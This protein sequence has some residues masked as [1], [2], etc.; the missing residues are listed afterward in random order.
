MLLLFALLPE[1]ATLATHMPAGVSASY[2]R[3]PDVTHDARVSSPYWVRKT[4]LI[5]NRFFDLPHASPFN[6]K[7]LSL[8]PL[9]RKRPH[10]SLKDWLIRAN[11]FVYRITDHCNTVE[12][13]IGPRESAGTALYGINVAGAVDCGL[14]SQRAYW[15]GTLLK[16]NGVSGSL[17]GL[18][19]HV[20][21]A[22]PDDASE[23]HWVLD[24]DY[25]TTPF[26]VDLFSSE[27]MRTAA[28][29]HYRFLDEAGWRQLY[30]DI[31]G[32]YASTENNA[33][34]DMNNLDHVAFLQS[35][36]IN[37]LWK[38]V[39]DGLRQEKG[40]AVMRPSVGTVSTRRLDFAHALHA[41]IVAAEKKYGIYGH[42]TEYVELNVRD[43][44]SHSLVSTTESSGPQL[45]I[46][47]WG[48]RTARLSLAKRSSTDCKLHEDVDGAIV[49]KPHSS[50]SI[51]VE[52]ACS[53]SGLL[54]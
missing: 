6:A 19:G 25:G 24:P 26:L 12:S 37:R 51:E 36:W 29:Q 3:L 11:E 48:Y 53:Y 9:L 30:A 17:L 1:S 23:K 8:N 27:E 50:V 4:S 45:R 38:I 49:V 42:R 33:F 31:V 32:F 43:F 47:N 46:T 2:M 21:L 7:R 10:E 40:S 22:I 54:H 18:M 5:A 34:Y 14:C 39:V 52:A 13:F 20:V 35:R 41:A 44:L 28:A 15:L 16:Q